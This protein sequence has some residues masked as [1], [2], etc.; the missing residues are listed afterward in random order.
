M[1]I[2][3]ILWMLHSMGGSLNKDI[4]FYFTFICYHTNV[5]RERRI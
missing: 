4:I 3:V 2:R 1:L 5:S